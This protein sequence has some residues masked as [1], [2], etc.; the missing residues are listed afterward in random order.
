MKANHNDQMIIYP[1][2]RGWQAITE[3]IQAHYGYSPSRLRTF[4]ECRK[5]KDGGYKDQ[6]WRI[7]HD[8]HTLFYN[9]QTY[10]TT[11]N[12]EILTK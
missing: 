12:V 10:F 1:T 2:E 4:M 11:T 5:T 3:H 7:I 6:M 8:L 9:G